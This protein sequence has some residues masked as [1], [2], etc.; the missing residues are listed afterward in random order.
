MRRF[1]GGLLVILLLGLGGLKS[2]RGSFSR[3]TIFDGCTPSTLSLS[4]PVSGHPIAII[5]DGAGRCDATD[6]NT[7]ESLHLNAGEHGRIPGTSVHV[8]CI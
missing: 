8:G 5:S 6:R 3:L 7:G 1:I 4:D 2:H